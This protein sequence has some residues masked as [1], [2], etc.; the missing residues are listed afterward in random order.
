MAGEPGSQGG[1]A[2]V[3]RNAFSAIRVPGSFLQIAARVSSP[4]R[5]RHRMLACKWDVSPFSRAIIV[6]PDHHASELQLR[7][8][9]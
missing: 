5:M 7:M 3:S 6:P 4:R 2:K 1:Q 9:I 8:L